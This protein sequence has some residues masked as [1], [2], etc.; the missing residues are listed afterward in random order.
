MFLPSTE[1]EHRASSYL[2]FAFFLD[3]FLYQRQMMILPDCVY[4]LVPAENIFII[5]RWNI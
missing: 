4:R 5:I 3:F 1:F 2:F